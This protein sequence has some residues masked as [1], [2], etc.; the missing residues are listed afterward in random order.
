MI[1]PPILSRFAYSV[2]NGRSRRMPAFALRLRER[3]GTDMRFPVKQ[4]Y[5]SVM[6]GAAILTA[7]CRAVQYTTYL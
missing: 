1:G 6:H 5:P 4:P 2:S 7:Y 3:P